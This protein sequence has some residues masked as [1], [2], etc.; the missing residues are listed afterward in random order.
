MK[1][2]ELVKGTIVDGVEPDGPV[3]VVNVEW[4]GTESVEIFYK[5]VF[6]GP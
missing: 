3:T 5:D 2:E 4:N 1:L 6:R